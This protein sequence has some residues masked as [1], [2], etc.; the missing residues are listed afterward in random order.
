[1]TLSVIFDHRERLN[2]NGEGII[3]VRIT[4]NRRVYYINTGIKVL[5]KHFVGGS[6]VGRADADTLN[7]R[8]QEIYVRIQEEINS[9]I[10]NKAINPTQIK[11]KIWDLNN[12]GNDQEII[13]F[14]EEQEAIMNLAPGT[15]KHY[16]T[17]RLRL[18]EYG[19]MLNWRDLTVENICKFDAWLHKLTRP[20][21]EAQM[22]AGEPEKCIDDCTVYNYHKWLKAIINRA[23]MYDKI[24]ANPYERMKGFFKRGDNNN[25]EFLTE[26]EMNAVESLHPVKGSQMAVARDLFVFQMHTGLSFADVQAFDF[27]AYKKINGKYVCI[28]NRVKTGIQYITQLSKECENILA[29]YNNKLPKINNSDYNHCLKA[30]GAAVG[31]EKP[32]H[33]HLA[34]HSFATRMLAKG[35]ALQNVSKMLG[36]SN[37]L[38]TQRYAKVLTESVMADFDIYEKR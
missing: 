29:K 5:K 33:S 36:H 6:I 19:N 17:L 26:E 9:C 24:P 4:H 28:G 37:V 13:D 11:K 31:I 35:A 12:S 1:M 18:M 22:L 30:L 10:K 2:K 7:K 38:Q 25:V 34:R 8:L 14:I 20:Q 16:K 23:V 32:L 21:S 27:S 3:E 15:L